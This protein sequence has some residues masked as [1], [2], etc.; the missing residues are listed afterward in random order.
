MI[1]NLLTKIITNPTVLQTLEVL[2]VS[3]VISGASYLMDTY[4]DNTARKRA[5]Q[6]VRTMNKG[7][8]NELLCKS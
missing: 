4:I 7:K 8:T 6:I 3:S 2:L 1:P 5:E